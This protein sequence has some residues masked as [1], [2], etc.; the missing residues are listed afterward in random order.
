MKQDFHAYWADGFHKVSGWVED[1]L[2]EFLWHVG[3][4]QIDHMIRGNLAEIGVFEGR[5]FIALSHMARP[6]EACIAID[7]FS[8]QDKNLDGAGA[9]S[10]EKLKFNIAEF[11]PAGVL[12]EFVQAD[13]LAL[14]QNEKIEIGTQYGPFRLF[15]IDGCHTAEHT[16]NDL[17]SAQDWLATGGV[18]V[19]DDYYNMHWPGVHEGVGIFY[20]RYVPRI[21]PF[22]Y[23]HNKL[24]F[25]SYAYQHRYLKHCVEK[26]RSAREFKVVPMYGSQVMVAV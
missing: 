23:T 25:T 6:G 17:L 19:I 16:V 22:L 24:F 9:G 1:G 18:I 5:F 8:E 4:F 14:T 2:R 3:A 21:K 7:V 12:F 11:A 20:N 15:S 26:F 13:S 10:L